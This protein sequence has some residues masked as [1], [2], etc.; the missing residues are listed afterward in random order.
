VIEAVLIGVLTQVVW[1]GVQELIRLLGGP[2]APVA[3]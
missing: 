3:A 2:D 1:L